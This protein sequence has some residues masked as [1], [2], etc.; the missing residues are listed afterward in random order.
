MPVIPAL[1]RQATKITNMRPVWT[2]YLR[3][4]LENKI[5]K[6]DDT[7]SIVAVLLTLHD[8]ATL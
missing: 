5:E 1:R 7:K 4:C 3:P 2:L 8:T 6:N